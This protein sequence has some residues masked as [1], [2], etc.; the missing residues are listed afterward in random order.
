MS[1][2]STSWKLFWLCRPQTDQSWDNTV[3]QREW[4]WIYLWKILICFT[5]TNDNQ[6][7]TDFV[8]LNVES[9]T[10]TD[11]CKICSKL[12]I[13]LGRFHHNNYPTL[14]V[15]ASNSD[16]EP[17]SIWPAIPPPALPVHASLLMAQARPKL[18]WL[19]QS[20]SQAAAAA[21]PSILFLSSTQ[22]K[23]L[24][25]LWPCLHAPRQ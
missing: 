22:T 16:P 13:R 10:I 3:W 2:V 14:T 12:H 21:T 18:F 6:R 1:G 4:A 8:Q 17:S 11:S 24:C 15:I 7:P 23:H 19:T 5:E 9:W 20:G 25:F